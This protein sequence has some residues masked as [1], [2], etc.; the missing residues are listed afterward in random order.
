M[1]L[2]IECDGDGRGGI[3]VWVLSWC[4]KLGVDIVPVVTWSKE[5]RT[6]IRNEYAVSSQCQRYQK[7]RLTQ[8]GAPDHHLL[9]NMK[10]VRIRGLAPIHGNG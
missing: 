9:L 7:L 5:Q 1:G 6:V 2:C 10:V 3:N 4:A 8:P